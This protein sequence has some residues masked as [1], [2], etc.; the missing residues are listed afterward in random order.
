MSF[1]IIIAAS[2]LSEFDLK[3]DRNFMS[4]SPAGDP[5]AR[6]PSGKSRTWMGDTGWI[7]TAWLTTV[8]KTSGQ[9]GSRNDVDGRHTG[10]TIW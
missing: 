2:S 6:P 4:L 10:F 5:D 8:Y 7:A 3:V 9:T 1:F